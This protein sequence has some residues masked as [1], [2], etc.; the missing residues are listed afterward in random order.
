MDGVVRRV[1]VTG[2]SGYLGRLLIRRLARCDDVEHI[3]ATDIRPNQCEISPKATFVMQD[4]TAPMANLFAEHRIDAVA[5][6]AFVIK[7]GRNRGASDSVNIGGAVNVLNACVESGVRHMLYLS[8]ATVYGAHADNPAYLT[9]TSPLRPVKGFQYAESKLEVESLLTDFAE[10]HPEVGVSVLRCCPVL[11]RSA[12]NF[13]ARSFSKS[14]LVAVR[15][16][17]PP[18]QFLHE[19]DAAEIMTGCLLNMASGIYNIGGVGGIG[20]I[21]MAEIANR[22]LIRLPAPMLYAL[23]NL[24]WRLRLQSSSP[25]CGLDFIRYRWI[26][27]SDKL[28]SE[29]GLQ[30]HHTSREAWDA[31]V[32]GQRLS[33]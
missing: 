17:N 23:T 33:E 7:P 27:S 29:H 31:F 9:E 14:V 3:L 15:G 16:Y 28:K 5:H 18:M 19:D 6:L 21:E 8:S 24:T 2:A 30:S 1:A 25:A 4:I 22:R 12:D 10:R 13:I 26:V 11:G 32:S 20:W